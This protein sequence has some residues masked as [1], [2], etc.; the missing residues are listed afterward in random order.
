MLKYS[1]LCELGEDQQTITTTWEIG[2]EQERMANPAARRRPA[3][4][5]GAPLPLSKQEHPRP[6]HSSQQFRVPGD[7]TDSGLVQPANTKLMTQS[8]PPFIF[9]TPPKKKYEFF[10]IP[11][12][13]KRATVRTPQGENN[14]LAVLS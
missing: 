10:V 9:V 5:P 1:V 6:K 3:E 13:L 11:E 12:C 14:N 8:S 4:H 2:Y 7:R